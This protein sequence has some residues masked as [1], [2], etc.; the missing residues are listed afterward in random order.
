MKKKKLLSL[1]LLVIVLFGVMMWCGKGTSTSSGQEDLTG[2]SQSVTKEIWEYRTER[3]LESMLDEANLTIK[4]AE[5][6]YEIACEKQ[7]TIDTVSAKKTVLKYESQYPEARAKVYEAG[8]E[9]AA[10]LGPDEYEAAMKKC[11]EVE[12]KYF[13]IMDAYQ[14]AMDTLEIA[15]GKGVR[16]AEKRIKRAKQNVYKILEYRGLL[17]IPSDERTKEDSIKVDHIY[18]GCCKIEN[19]GWGYNVS[20]RLVSYMEKIEEAETNNE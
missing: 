2:S 3:C 7:R 18:R 17:T 9:L 16:E 19:E 20:E 1:S 4:E 8:N 6:N 5:E 10:S 15:R 13:P 12:E 14:K 11:R